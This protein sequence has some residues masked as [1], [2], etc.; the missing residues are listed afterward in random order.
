LYLLEHYLY[1]FGHISCPQTNIARA[2]TRARVEV[3][4]TVKKIGTSE[5]SLLAADLPPL[6]YTKASLLNRNAKPPATAQDIMSSYLKPGSKRRFDL[7]DHSYNP[8][9]Y[10]LPNPAVYQQSRFLYYSRSS[11]VDKL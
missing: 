3:G 7:G 9:N 4:K 1:G 8:D 5:G 11:D 6:H 2:Q 10:H